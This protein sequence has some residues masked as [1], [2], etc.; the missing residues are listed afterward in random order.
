MRERR[1]DLHVHTRYSDG[2]FSPEELVQCTKENSVDCI[3]VCDHDS[4]NGLDEALRA[5][6]SHGVEIVPAVEI[7]AEEDAKEVHLLGYYIDYKDETLKQALIQIREDRKQRAYKMVDALNDHSFNIDAEDMIKSFGDVAISRLHIAQYMESRGL[8]PSWREA[9]KRYIG[10]DKC[11]YVGAFSLS[12]K[13]A[14]ELITAA[15]GIAVIAH[16]GLTKI[17]N[18]LPKLIEQGMKGIEAFHAEHSSSVAQYYERYAIE[19][20]LL[21]TGGS[22][23]HGMAKGRIL[24][25][26]VTVPYSYVEELKRARNA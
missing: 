21:V 26:K 16:P 1:A 14:I 13:Q 8:I 2:S 7:S 15:G 20:K 22:D 4:I 24:I 6:D 9:F 12:P 5:G 17:D 23:C 25:G 11:C 3:G 18:M 10:D 19:H